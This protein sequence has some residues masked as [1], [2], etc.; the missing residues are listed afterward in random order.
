MKRTINKFSLILVA[1]LGI[2]GTSCLKDEGFDNGE[3][4]S[5]T[6]N[7]SGQEFVSIPL[8]SR[9]NNTAALGIESKTGTQAIKIF[10]LSY[11]AA[12]PAPA[13][14][15][16]TLA[17]NNSLITDP[18]L[19]PLPAS[20][21]TISTLEVP[22][23]AGRR[24][25]DSVVLNINTSSL[26]PTQKYALGFTL[27]SVS[28]AGVQIPSN[29]KNL[30][31]VFTIKNRFDGIYNIRSHMMH[32]ADRPASWVRTPFDYPYE[33][34][35]ITTGPNTV[36]WNNTAFGDGFHPLMTPGVSGFGATRVAFEFDA[37][38]DLIA[39]WN[40]YPSPPNGRAFNID[41][42]YDGRWDPA[43]KTIYAGFFMTQPGFA[44]IPI[45]DTLYFDRARP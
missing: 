10:A 28:K 2:T 38:N 6:G 15:T 26:D 21:Y 29:L 37:N 32:P 40:A 22:F 39:V 5:I 3:Y 9:P 27:M 24:V 19:T 13:P 23:Q 14:F 44:P 17:I 4:G 1:L 11:D 31:M 7:T 35:L 16:A 43:T 20:A 34:E 18:S 45:Y 33:I 8:S 12:D 41:P 36:E 25:S 30:I 42:A